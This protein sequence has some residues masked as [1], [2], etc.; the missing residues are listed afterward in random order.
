M[1]EKSKM[2]EEGHHM[3]LQSQL[4]QIL[5]P[6]RVHTRTIDRIAYANDASYFHMV[7]QAV[8]QPNSISEIQALYKFTQQNRVPMTFRAA[9]TSLS[10]QAVT[11]GILVDIS[12][13]WGQFKVENDAALIRTQ[14]GIVG[15]F[16]NNVLKPYERRI[17]P[18]PASIDACMMGGI[19][20]NNSS[21]MCCGVTENAYRTIHSMTFVLPNGFTLDTAAPDANR[22]FE[23]E[24]PHIANGLLELK[25]RLLS[26]DSAHLPWR[27]VPGDYADDKK[28]N[29]LNQRNLRMHPK[30]SL[31][32]RVHR[33][34][35][36]KNNNGYLLN[37]FLDFDIPLD[38]LTHLLI[39]SEGTLGFIAEAVLHTLPDYPRRYTGQLYF[40]TVQDAA[41]AIYPLKQSGARAAEIMDRPSLRS[42]E[43]LHGAP[44]LLAHLPETAAAILVEYQGQTADDITTFRSAAARAIPKIKLLHDAEFTENP[45]EQAALWKLR[46]GIIPSVGAMR[47]PATTL[48]CEDVVFPVQSLADGI[49]DLQHLFVEHGYPEGVVFGHAKDG[50]L[51]FLVAQ[52][53]N[54][55]SDVSRFAT[56]M[57]DLVRVVSGKYDGALKAEHGTG[58]NT[59][60]FVE[61]EWGSNAYAIMRDL[62]SLLDPDNMLNPGVVINSDPR[63][64]VT[65]VKS[66]APVAPEVDKCIE[67]GFCE[68]KCPSRRL[69]LTP[70]QRI[71][72]QREI[73]RLR[74]LASDSPELDSLKSAQA[75]VPGGEDAASSYKEL[76]D[77]YTYAGI[78]TCAVD[79]LCATACPVNINTGELTKRLRAEA[80]KNEKP[81][82]WIS[83]HFDFVERAVGWGTDLGHAA[84][85][86]IG[87]NGVKSISIAA[88]KL[89]SKRLPKWNHHIPYSDS[90][91]FAKHPRGARLWNNSRRQESSDSGEYI[92]FPSC[93][94]RQLGTP[95]DSQYSSLSGTLI[96]IAQRANITLTIP[97]AE[98]VCCGMPFSSK[99]Y[100][101]AY[102][103]TLHKTLLKLWEWSGQGKFSIVIDTTS[104]A[105]TLRTCSDSLSPDD[106][107]I[108]NQ[109]TILDSIEFIH[110]TIL[111]RLNI[112]PIDEDVVLHPNCSARKLGLDSKL[113]SIAQKC[114]KSAT[115]PLNLGC[116]AFAGDRGLLFPELTASATEKESAEVL[117]KDYGGYFSTNITCE[118]GMSEATG[119][120]YVGIVYLVEKASR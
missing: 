12:K 23:G 61:T 7:P 59:A 24:Q 111:P 94:S 9:G 29:L 69:T 80:L 20:A 36:M 64:H 19:L 10:G 106:L 79:G 35:Q 48:L 93:I 116:C 46:K 118:I 50:N 43:H 68:S 81:A 49:T 82:L 104:C 88:E 47:P 115:V 74:A 66:M 58:R 98:G 109:L 60:P 53:F 86:V 90:K 42:I 91:V 108:Y 8:V 103:A 119:K 38:I 73:S 17:G 15:G 31:A 84:E 102:K 55:D 89:T 18:D 75:A 33:R 39:G 2:K 117:S 37:A 11:D 71:V 113:V 22:I 44:A 34:Y 57:D 41:D 76:T 67:C 5:A 52:S 83:D 65:H 107:T 45:V 78:E 26:A 114:A 72:V 101:A 85:K 28:E 21:G 56:F 16:L 87:T 1:K 70:R 112:H 25:R 13:H 54:T 30:E 92:Y 110:D 100:N 105:H 62:K 97:D 99:G 3:N 77:D 96:T 4:S 63:A 120:D 27:S 95:H 51:H 40:K 32:E 6:S 14:P